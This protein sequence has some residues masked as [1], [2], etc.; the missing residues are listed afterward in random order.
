L[1]FQLERIATPPRVSA[2]G[3]DFYLFERSFQLRAF[4]L[5]YV[6]RET[7]KISGA[8]LSHPLI[9]LFS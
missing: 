8:G 2:Q 6:R 9:F 1:G 7:I 4:P 5:R 3:N